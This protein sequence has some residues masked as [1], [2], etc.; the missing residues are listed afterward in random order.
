VVL[1][2]RTGS[3]IWTDQITSHDVRD[4]DFQN[5]PVLIRAGD[6]DLVVGAGKSGRVIAWDR[7]THARVWETAVGLHRHDRGSLPTRATSVC[8]GFLGGVESPMAAASGRVF[9]PVVDL[10]FPESANG[11]SAVSFLGFDYAKGTGAIEA[12]DAATGRRLWERRVGSAV[13]GC[14]TVANDVVFTATYD[15]TLYGLAAS[16]GRVLWHARAA[17][18]VNACPAVA[19]N[20]LFIAAATDHPSFVR[21]PPPVLEAYVLR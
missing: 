17:G 5:P 18:G 9:L 21:E 16:D 4:L 11:T 1:D 13:F 19:S 2:A 20:M 6:R 3:L 12:L 7:S 15:G 10:C 14:A 8:P